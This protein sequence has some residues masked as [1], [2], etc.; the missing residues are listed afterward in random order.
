MAELYPFRIKGRLN[1]SLGFP[2]PPDVRRLLSDV[3]SKYQRQDFVI[4]LTPV[5][6]TLIVVVSAE[7]YE[8]ASTAAG[9][10]A[11]GLRQLGYL[12]S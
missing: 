7:K 6:D 9:K 12:G 8:T 4:Q 2:E 5:G 11:E 1:K 3:R 10:V